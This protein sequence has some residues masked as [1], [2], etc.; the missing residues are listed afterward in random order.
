MGLGLKS[1][2]DR[3]AINRMPAEKAKRITVARFQ[4]GEDL[5]GGAGGVGHG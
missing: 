4:D 1:P 3:A 2:Y 5:G